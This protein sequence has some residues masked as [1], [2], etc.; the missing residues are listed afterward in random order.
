MVRDYVAR[1][2]GH[3][4]LRTGLPDN[5]GLPWSSRTTFLIER[6]KASVT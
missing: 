5:I 3:K 6:S 1:L 2:P 4:Q